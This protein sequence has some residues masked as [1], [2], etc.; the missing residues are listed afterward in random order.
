MHGRCNKTETRKRVHKMRP[1]CFDFALNGRL[2][3]KAFTGIRI[4]VLLSAS[5]VLRGTHIHRLIVRMATTCSV[6]AAAT[7]RMPDADPPVSSEAC[8]E[9][10]E[11]REKNI[12]SNLYHIYKQYEEGESFIVI[13][14]D[15]E[16][17]LGR[18]ELQF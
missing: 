3:G 9:D 11:K 1:V 10:E 13:C 8:L 16:Y 18:I 12:L 2:R 4:I 6:M 15:F 7:C 17:Q 5:C 14:P